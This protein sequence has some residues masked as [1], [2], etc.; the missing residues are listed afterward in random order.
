MNRSFIT[1]AVDIASEDSLLEG[2]L[3][4]EEEAVGSTPPTLPVSSFEAAKREIAALASALAQAEI[5]RTM[6]SRTNMKL[7]L[8][9]TQSELAT[10]LRLTKDYGC[11]LCLITRH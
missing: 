6:S 5:D 3:D 11:V 8:Q 7:Q 10:S 1:P 2:I 9:K 4:A